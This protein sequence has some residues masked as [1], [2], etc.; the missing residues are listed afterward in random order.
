MGGTYGQRLR[1]EGYAGRAGGGQ[2]DGLGDGL[3]ACRKTSATSVVQGQPLNVQGACS[4]TQ[5]VER[6]EFFVDDI[7]QSPYRDV[8]P[9]Y[10]W[11]MDTSAFAVGTHVLNSGAQREPRC[12]ARK[13]RAFRS[14]RRRSR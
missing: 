11:T 14:S 8:A 7:L 6:T 5:T 4:A 1:G 3:G 13:R 10:T 9:P 2:Q 12:S